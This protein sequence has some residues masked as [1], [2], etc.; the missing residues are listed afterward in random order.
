MHHLEEQSPCFHEDKK[1]LNEI[2]TEETRCIANV[3]IRVERVIR[4]TR[5]RFKILKGPININFLNTVDGAPSFVDK[6]VKVCSIS[7][8]LL[9]G[10]VPLD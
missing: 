10:V 8:N 1:Q 5:T 7:T 6:I 9:P 3:R 2:E 4:V